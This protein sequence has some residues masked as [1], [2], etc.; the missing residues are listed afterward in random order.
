MIESKICRLEGRLGQQARHADLP[1]FC[2]YP[3]NTAAYTGW[4][5]GWD[6]ADADIR[7]SQ[8]ES[9]ATGYEPVPAL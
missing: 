1:R 5:Q 4:L 3:P 6:A 8:P 2:Y 7:T 9:S